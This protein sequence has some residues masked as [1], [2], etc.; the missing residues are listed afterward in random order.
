MT[1]L[2]C[3]CGYRI[4]QPKATALGALFL[5]AP[6]PVSMAEG[7][8]ALMERLASIRGM[9]EPAD[10]PDATASRWKPKR[11]R[12]GCGRCGHGEPI[13]VFDPG[14]STCGLCDCPAFVPGRRDS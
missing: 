4:R 12:P 2:V 1:G 10:S 8:A 11:I 5:P 6:E 7:V 9:S 14:G 13:H 3:G